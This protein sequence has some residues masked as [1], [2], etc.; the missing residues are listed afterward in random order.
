MAV[1]ADSGAGWFTGMRLPLILVLGCICGSTAFGSD[2]PVELD[3]LVVTPPD[4][5]PLD[6]GKRRAELSR[7]LPGLGTHLPAQK[8]TSDEVLEALGLK[9][10][11][12]Q[13][14][15]PADKQRLLD[16]RDKLRS[17]E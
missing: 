16:L 11:R 12:L 9:G 7:M 13:A 3:P 17:L 6:F 8:S 1:C 4:L 14:L 15:H 2:A 5:G 10:D